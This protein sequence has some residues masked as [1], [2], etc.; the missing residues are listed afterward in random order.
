MPSE[1]SFDIVSQFDRQELVN[2]IDQTRRELNNRFDFKGS[3]FSIA[4]EGDTITV[5]A[6][7]ELR[8]AAIKDT[9]QGKLIRR[10]LSLKILRWGKIEEASG[11]RSR[12]VVSLVR[13]IPGDLARQLSRYIREGHPKVKA[14]IQGDAVRVSGKNRDDLQAVIAELRTREVEFDQPLQFINYR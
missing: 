14:I 1:S 7:S 9:L 8:L 2:A 6:E 12:Q 10:Q 3:P 11:G 13:G 5:V 4:L